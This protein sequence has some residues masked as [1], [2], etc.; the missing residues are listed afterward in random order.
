MKNVLVTGGAGYIGSHIIELLVKKNFK[1]FII[2]NLTTGHQRLI[3]KNAKF[4]NLDINKFNKVKK[5]IEKNNIDSVIHLAAK[6][7]VVEAEKKPK[8]YFKNNIDG[9]LNLLRACRDSAVKN[10]IFSSTCAVYTSRLRHVQE[11]SKTY[12]KG[13]Y[14]FTKLQGEK[15]IKKYFNSKKENYAILRYFNVVGASPS[16]KIGQVNH[17]DQLFKNLSV[18]IIKKNPVFNIYGHDYS[19]SDGTCVRDFIHVYDLADIHIKTLLKINTLNKSIILNCGYGKGISVLEVMNEFK[20]FSRNKVK[21][22]FKGK[23]KG[24]IVEMVSNTRRLKK[25]L[26]WKPKFYNLEKMVKSSINWE[27][28][29][30][31]Y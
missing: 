31:N 19:T 13:T 24:D 4:F 10:F 17:D 21:I 15:M 27:K 30:N 12:P 11:T 20:K 26:E 2:D 7:N 22:N 16:N 6:T 18:A 1:V 9:T 3:N 5:I 23:R 25:F 29:L 28:K 14:G 8:V